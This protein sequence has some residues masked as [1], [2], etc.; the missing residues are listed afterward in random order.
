MAI[1]TSQTGSSATTGASAVTAEK[2]ARR[3]PV[4]MGSVNQAI[5]Y[6]G[7]V[8][9]DSQVNSGEQWSHKSFQ[10]QKRGRTLVE[11]Q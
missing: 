9:I 1:A 11:M 6:R 4:F 2:S 7:Y 5:N 3:R 10:G 8:Y